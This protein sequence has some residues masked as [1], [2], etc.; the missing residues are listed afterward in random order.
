M[1]GFTH[2]TFGLFLEGHA[3]LPSLTLVGLGSL[4]PDLDTNSQIAKVFKQNKSEIKHRGLLHAPF[5]AGVI[6]LLYYFIFRNFAI[7]P[8]IVGYLSHIF[9]DALTKEGAPLL[10]PLTKRKFHFLSIK[11]GS[12]IDKTLSFFFL[13]FFILRFLK[14]F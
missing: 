14:L 12:I 2:L 5:T 3:S 10:Y 1:L 11:T 4:F 13:F 8:F 6:F 9:L 7:L